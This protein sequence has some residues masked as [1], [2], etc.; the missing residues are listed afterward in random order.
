[1]ETD[2]GPDQLARSDVAD[3]VEFADSEQAGRE[4]ARVAEHELPPELE[5]LVER[6]TT[7][8]ASRD[9]FIWKWVHLLAPRFTFPFI[10]SAHEDAVQDIKTAATLFLTLLD[11]VL[12]KE[13][14]LPTFQEARKVPFPH[15]AVTYTWNDVDYEYVEFTEHVWNWL[16]DRLEAAPH[17]EEYDALFRYD[18]KQSIAA[19]EYSYLTTDMPQITRIEE[20][21]RRESHNMM[22]YPYSDIDLMFGPELSPSDVSLVRKAVW[23]AQLMARIGNWV[24]TW[25]R[26]LEEGDYSSGIVIYA[27][28]TGVISYD[29]LERIENDDDAEFSEQIIERIND[30]SIEEYF[31]DRWQDNYEALVS[32]SQEFATIDIRPYVDGMRE[33][34]RFHLASR[35]MK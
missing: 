1:M 9:P 33:V 3:I 22:M 26:E 34:L 4:M 31:L 11:D 16:S 10:D 12:E 2:W 15:Q 23:N 13:R 25:E 18:L 19:I 24:S 29:D 6:Y 20:H 5:R 7:L 35:G 30:A 8:R 17:R 14:D 28:Q 27:L 32:I 21:I